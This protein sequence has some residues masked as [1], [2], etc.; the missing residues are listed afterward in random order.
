MS[1]TSYTALTIHD[2]ADMIGKVIIFNNEITELDIYAE[3]HMKARVVKKRWNIHNNDMS[4]LR[5]VVHE[6]FVDFSEFENHNH[7][8]QNANY[9][10]DEGK[11]CLT[12]VEAGQYNPRDSIFISGAKELLPFNV[13]EE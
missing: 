12:A 10:D 4:D 5:E 13:T 2:L 7:K 3:E 9:Y 6:I 11:P 1:K 8:Y